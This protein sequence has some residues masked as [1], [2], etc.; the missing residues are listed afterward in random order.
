MSLKLAAF[1]YDIKA[2]ETIAACKRANLNIPKQVSVLGVDNDELICDYTNPAISSV[3]IDHEAL[4]FEAART[5]ENLMRHPESNRLKK[6]FMPVDK[7]VERESTAPVAPGV[8]L[9]QKA[10]TYIEKHATDGIGVPDVVRHLGVSRRLIDRRFSDATGSSIRRIIEDRRLE[11][12][13]KRLR[14]TKLSISKISRLC[15]YANEQRL[16]Y[17]FKQR[18]G[19]PMSEWRVQQSKTSDGKTLSSHLGR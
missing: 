12:V 18:F 19:C 14:T 7:V 8:H 2:Q 3:R 6:I 17:V 15:G 11:Q 4:G 16:K 13:K 10:L 1:A 9:V 5:L